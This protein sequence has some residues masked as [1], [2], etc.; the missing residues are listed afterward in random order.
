MTSMTMR[1][2]GSGKTNSKMRDCIK[3]AAYLFMCILGPIG[4]EDFCR[5]KLYRYTSFFCVFETTFLLSDVYYMRH[6][7]AGAKRACLAESIWSSSISRSRGHR[8][9][10]DAHWL[11]LMTHKECSN[12][13]ITLLES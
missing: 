13:V 5:S 3:N 12:A 6:T 4:P 11:A 8:R 10:E 9:G 7:I 1:I 2:G